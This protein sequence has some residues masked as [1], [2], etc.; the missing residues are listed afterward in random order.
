MLDRNKDTD[1][2]EIIEMLE[3]II[4]LLK[5]RVNRGTRGNRIKINRVVRGGSYY[6]FTK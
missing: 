1:T 4:C 5:G 2:E 3:E 6:D